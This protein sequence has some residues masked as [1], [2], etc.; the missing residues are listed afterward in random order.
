MDKTRDKTRDKAY[1]RQDRVSRGRQGGSWNIEVKRNV[2][3]CLGI[4]PF[5]SWAC[6]IIVF[7]ICHAA[8]ILLISVELL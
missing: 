4:I 3:S 8:F 1:T 7:F 5:L 6:L 2:V